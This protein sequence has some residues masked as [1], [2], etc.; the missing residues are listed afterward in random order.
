[1]KSKENALA[2]LLRR[3]LCAWLAAAALELLLTP[4][5]SRSLEGVEAL[6]A[7]SLPRLLLVAAA[8]LGLQFLP[9]LRRLGS[10][11]RWLLPGAF[12]LYAGIG[13]TASRS[14]W[15]VLGC[16]ALLGLLILW[17][18][19]GWDASEEV[20]APAE[21]PRP[22]WA[23]ATALLALGFFG[24]VS[25]WTVA[26]LH[27]LE[28][29]TY[30]FGI[31]SQMFASMR[32]TGLPVT[33]LERGY[34]LSHFAV[35]VSPVY[36]LLLP[37]YCL[38]PRPETLQVLQA[39]VMASAALPLWKLG[40][41]HGLTGPRRFLLC[42]LLLLAPAFAG[43]A[44]FDL[45]E[46]CFLTAGLLWLFW[47]LDR[48]SR[49]VTLLAALL[50]LSVKEDAA[51]YVGVVGLWVSLRAGLRPERRRQLGTGLLL[52]G[53]ALLWFAGTTLWLSGSGE[54]VM[55]GRYGN[56]IYEPGGGLVS[57]AKAILLC[58]LKV[59]WECM[60]GEK[61]RYALLILG[62]LLGLPLLTRR[63]ERLLLLLPWVLFNLLSDYPYQ[64][65]LYF[66]YSFGSLAC[67]LYLTCLNLAPRSGE[68]ARPALS[69]RRLAALGLAAAVS[70]GCFLGT[71]GPIFREYLG[72]AA[73][74][75]G[76]FA[77]VRETLA[78][79]PAD[80]AVAASTFFTTPLSDRE[81]VYD[82]R[83]V[84]RERLLAVDYVV[85]SA[86]ETAR[87]F[88]SPDAADGLARLRELLAENGFRRTEELPGVLEIWQREPA[89]EDRTAGAPAVRSSS[90]NFSVLSIDSNGLDIV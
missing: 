49:P 81:T 31:F 72:K 26:R 52:L 67:L 51:V 85:L 87:R 44:A 23:W 7:M 2:A 69:R 75:A 53:G 70:L 35:H 14:R 1:M 80:A 5:G 65:S 68:A 30:D 89:E 22:R 48:G 61:L 3:G 32:R 11:E 83:Y 38:V 37:F 64:H 50:T 74:R 73:A 46:N 15:F 17:A 21:R 79:V 18:L 27:T 63:W 42:A 86:T 4:A 9:V 43:G 45:H 82:L 12:A 6:Q 8:L 56:L 39:A 55:S 28:V 71:V 58:P 33:T 62:P 41:L 29:P 24:V 77:A 16:L 59:L 60:E 78:E 47:G 19:R 54:G 40:G 57:A 88:A 34:P 66:Q 20:P 76:T 25:L 10:R 84:S 13:L 36:Y 90:A